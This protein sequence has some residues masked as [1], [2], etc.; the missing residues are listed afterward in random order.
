MKVVLKNCNVI[1]INQIEPLENMDIH[2][3]GSI[4]TNI[5]KTGILPYDEAYVIDCTQRFVMPGL[6]D[7]HYHL[8]HGDEKTL[9]LNVACGITSLRNMWGNQQ[10]SIDVPEIDSYKMKK[11]IE[12]KKLLGP[13]LINTSRICDGEYPVIS[14]NRPLG[15]LGSLEQFMK[16]AIAEGAD[17]IKVYE[18]LDKDLFDLLVEL[19]NER[20]LKIVGHIPQMV[21]KKMFMN[22]TFSLEHTSSLELK[23][24]DYLASTNILW[25]PTLIVENAIIEL[26]DGKERNLIVEEY[27]KYVP[28]ATKNLWSD[29]SAKLNG[30]SATSENPMNVHVDKCRGNMEKVK[31]YY[32]LGK[33]VATGTD[34]ANPY[35]YP[36]FGIHMELKLIEACGATK[37]QA[38]KAATINAAKVLE[39]EDRK[40]TIEIGKDADLIILTRNPLENLE[41]T[42]TIETVILMG[43]VYNRNRLDEILL[44]CIES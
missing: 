22:K 8:Y 37:Y 28:Q 6:I 1:P 11:D 24:I 18:M 44:K 43:A 29:I 27:L 31:H 9:S 23:D 26:A 35:C 25:V 39:L 34:Y 38:L 10:V 41:H 33:E 40:G 13:T 19:A 17:Q 20:E 12:S 15:S 3:L 14:T 7:A 21:N 32:E 4:I 42:L 5:T 36:G 16:E 30:I 2:I